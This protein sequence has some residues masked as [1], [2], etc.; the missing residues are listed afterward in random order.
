[1]NLRRFAF[2]SMLVSLAFLPAA[3]AAQTPKTL[4]VTLAGGVGGG[5]VISSPGGINCPGDCTESYTHGT[6]VTLTAMANPGFIFTG[7]SGDCSGASCTVKLNQNRDVTATFST[8]YTLSVD[9]TGA[10]SGTVTSFPAGIDC[11]VDCGEA[12]GDGTVVTLTAAPAVGSVFSGWSGDCTGTGTC[13]VTMSQARSVTA[14]FSVQ[15]FELTVS[16]AGAGSGSVTSSPAGIDCGSD[17]SETYDYNTEVTLTATPATGSVFG[18]WGGACTGTGS[19]VVTMTEARSVTATFEVGSFVLTVA[20]DGDGAGTVTSSPA[21]IDCGFDCSES[22]VYNTEVTLTAAAGERS[23]FTGWSGSGCS[24][25]GTCVVTMDDAKSVTATF[26]DIGFDFYTLE[27]CRVIDTRSVP[28]PLSSG[29]PLIVDVAGSCGVPADA[30]AVSLNVTVIDATNSGNLRL[31]PGDGSVPT[32]STLNFQTGVNRANN[33]FMSL[34]TNGDGT[35]GAAA[36]L[37]GGTGTIH[38]IV[39]VNGYYK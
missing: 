5:T 29:V 12:Y 17:C 6:D 33:T 35:I 1:M 7:W 8:S 31:Y 9:K 28:S 26:S 30:K 38:L 10:G 23:T 11:G 32:A 22:Y 37:N 34:A 18:G 36:F 4:T 19:C 3:L 14:M 25:T 16:L 39:D 2:L 24:G 27:P 21:G 15:T 20:K 13:V